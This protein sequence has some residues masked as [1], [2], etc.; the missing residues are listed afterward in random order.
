LYGSLVRKLI[1][2]R[3]SFGCKGTF[4][5]SREQKTEAGKQNITWDILQ[6]KGGKWEV[7]SGKR[8]A[9]SKIIIKG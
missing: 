3:Y 1:K 7:R 2:S 5:K 6:F 9:G 8:K 4:P